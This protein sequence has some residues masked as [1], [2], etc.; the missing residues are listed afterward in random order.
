[1]KQLIRYFTLA[2]L[3]ISIGQAKADDLG[4]WP[5]DSNYNQLMLNTGYS[6][7]AFHLG[8]HVGLE[9]P[10]KRTYKPFNP[11]LLLKI[12]GVEL[13]PKERKFYRQTTV[14]PFIQFYNHKFNHTNLGIGAAYHYRIISPYRFYSSIGLEA[15]RAFQF[16][17]DA[18]VFDERDNPSEQALLSNGYYQLGAIIEFGYEF[19]RKKHQSIYYRLHLGTLFPYN[20]VLNA[21][22]KNEFGIRVINLR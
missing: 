10:V 19:N 3:L 15:G 16:Y 7:P 12:M 1:M 20:H 11:A 5:V 8:F 14:E 4:K 13:L 17:R 22:V 6:A 2:I 18:V 9:I 21:Y